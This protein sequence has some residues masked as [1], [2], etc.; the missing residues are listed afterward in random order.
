MTLQKIHPHDSAFAAFLTERGGEEEDQVESATAA[1]R[2]A[3]C[4]RPHRATLAAILTV[5]TPHPAPCCRP[6]GPTPLG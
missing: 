2:C 6:R 1:S 3:H 4:I 5:H